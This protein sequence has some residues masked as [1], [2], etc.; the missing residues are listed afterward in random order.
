MDYRHP[1]S[2]RFDCYF[3]SLKLGYSADNSS[4]TVTENATKEQSSKWTRRARRAHTMCVF[5]DNINDNDNVNKSIGSAHTYIH[6]VSVL[7]CCID[8]WSLLAKQEMRDP[9]TEKGLRQFKGQSGIT[10]EIV[11]DCR[12]NSARQCWLDAIG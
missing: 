8:I 4:S 3:P 6:V 1:G 5:R 2:A 10:T 11:L 7:K 12:T 9:S